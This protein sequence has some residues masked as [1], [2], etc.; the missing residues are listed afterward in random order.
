MLVVLVGSY[1]DLPSAL[2]RFLF[3]ETSVG[4]QKTAGQQV[5]R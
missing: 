3:F 2:T 4:S 1:K 5:Y